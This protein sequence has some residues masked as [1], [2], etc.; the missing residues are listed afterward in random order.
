MNTKG[1]RR[2]MTPGPVK[3]YGIH[4]GKGNSRFVVSARSAKEAAGSLGVPYRYML[5]YGSQ[6]WNIAEINAAMTQ[7]G[8]PVDMG[9]I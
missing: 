6:T 2:G 3:V 4:L 5:D 8:V 9:K 7:P 1:N